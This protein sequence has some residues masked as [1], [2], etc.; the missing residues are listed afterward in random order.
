MPQ[1]ADIERRLSRR[2][3]GKRC[4][5]RGGHRP[6]RFGGAR[7]GLGAAAEDECRHSRPRGGE[8]DA[9]RFGQAELGGLRPR[10]DDDGADRGTFDGVGGGLENA[11][12]RVGVDED[13]RIGVGPKL[14]ETRRIQASGLADGACIADPEDRAV[15]RRAQGEQQRE[16]GGGCAVGGH[17]GEHLVQRRAQKSLAQPRIG[18]SGAGGEP[19]RPRLGDRRA[20]KVHVM[21]YLS[22]SFRSSQG[23]SRS[24]R[25]SCP[26]AVIELPRESRST[27]CFNKSQV[28]LPS[29]P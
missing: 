6:A 7:Y 16:T 23:D 17:S 18:K 20:S 14:D 13:D 9:T 5:R 27:G 25:R 4:R 24:A 15:G 12:R 3:G 11:A 29:A 10:L 19:R 1:Q 28:A 22:D 8:G 2:I 21:F 26:K